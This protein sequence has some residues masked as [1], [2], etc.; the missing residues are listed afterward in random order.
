L[1]AVVAA[2]AKIVPPLLAV[3]QE[4]RFDAFR[5]PLDLE[6]EEEDAAFYHGALTA[7][8]IG[9]ERLSGQ[10]AYDALYAEAE[11]REKLSSESLAALDMVQRDLLTLARKGEISYRLPLDAGKERLGHLVSVWA[12]GFLWEYDR[13]REAWRSLVRDERCKRYFAL[14]VGLGTKPREREDTRDI[15]P[16]LRLEMKV[17]MAVLLPSAVRHI[18]QFWRRHRAR[19]ANPAAPSFEMRPGRNAPCACGSGLK[20]KR[21]CGAAGQ[22]LTRER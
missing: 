22:G 9:P 14:V 17:V 7:I 20:Y 1:E 18:E 11:N 19:T 15:D 10:A 8:T 5:K 2:L 21:C 3:A 4:P 6:K 13:D 12:E 16:K